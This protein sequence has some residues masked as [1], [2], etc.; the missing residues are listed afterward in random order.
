MKTVLILYKT[1][2]LALLDTLISQLS[3]AETTPHIVSLD[4]EIDDALVKR[5][6]PFTSG[7]ALQNRTTPAA[8]VRTEEVVR[9]VYDHKALSF[10]S[11]RNVSCT[12]SLRFSTHVYLASLLYHV[13]VLERFMQS[14][15]EIER[16]IVPIPIVPV[17]K[18]S[19]VLATEE[20][21]MVYEAAR[22]VTERRGIVCEAYENHSV[23]SQVKTRWEGWTFS[24]K[25]TLFGAVLAFLNACMAHRY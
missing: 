5:N 7:R 12:R 18:T 3:E 11:Y 21:K 13:D 25:R 20:L 14:A 22:L 17:S 1:D 6:V 10:L 23:V 2:Q 16:V 8:Y 4:A 9:A 15:P 19:D 24:V